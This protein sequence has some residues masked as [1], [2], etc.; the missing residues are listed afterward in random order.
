MMHK[1]KPSPFENP[2]NGGENSNVPFDDTEVK[3]SE[4]DKVQDNNSDSSKKGM[5]IADKIKSE[6]E[7]DL[8]IEALIR[9]YLPNDYEKIKAAAEEDDTDEKDEPNTSKSGENSD[10]VFFEQKK[11]QK[12]DDEDIKIFNPA[13]GKTSESVPE[14]EGMFEFISEEQP[15]KTKSESYMSSDLHTN[16]EDDFFGQPYDK[17]AESDEN[18]TLDES[19]T[20]Q[21][22]DDADTVYEQ[23]EPAKKKKFSLFG[24]GKRKKNG[25][26]NTPE[27]AV[28]NQD[29]FNSISQ[30][31]N[32]SSNFID[33]TA[34]AGD[35]YLTPPNAQLYEVAS[36]DEEYQTSRA[37]RAEYENNAAE[38][39]SDSDT[40]VATAVR[41]NV[42]E[43]EYD[44]SAAMDSSAKMA[45]NRNYDS[46][47]VGGTE[48]DDD[49]EYN[50]DNSG[51]THVSY[52]FSENG[53][54]SINNSA[55][56]SA[57]TET[58]E[59]SAISENDSG[60]QKEDM[61]ETDMNLMW[62]LGLEDELEKKVGK[63]KISK[64]AEKIKSRENDSENEYVAGEY[65]DRS[66]TRSIID[67][68]KRELFYTKIKL[69]AS[70]IFALILLFFE[71]MSLIKS[72]GASLHLS[73]PLDPSVY[74][75]V[76]IMA[77]LQI[78]LLCCSFAYRQ[79]LSGFANIF[80]GAPSPE[81]ITSVM[82]IFS[83]VHSAASAILTV[84][85]VEPNVY[86][87][88]VAVCIVMT[89]V[90]TLFTLKREVLSF[91][92]VSSKR[93]KYVLKR[94]SA[95]DSELEV[96]AFSNMTEDMPDVLKIEKTAFVDGFFTRMNRP[97]SVNRLI[98]I[99][100]PVI[101]AISVLFF[102][103][104]YRSTSNLSGAFSTAYISV[105]FCFP[106][107]VFFTYS[108]PF[109]SA[110]RNAYE[111]DSTIIGETSIDEYSGASVISF[112][113]RNVFPSYG[114]K[115][116]NINIYRN[117]RIDRVLYYAS[118]IFKAVGGPL[119]DVFEVATMEMEH[120]DNVTAVSSEHGY[121]EA[122]V[123]GKNIILGKLS[124]I[125]AGGFD[126]PGEVW[127][128]DKYAEPDVSVMYMLRDGKMIAKMYIKYIIDSDFEFI[129]K[130]L[131]SNG[132]CVGIKT[133]DPNI[134]EQ[135]IGRKIKINK[136][137]VRVLR[138]RD[139]N[140]LSRPTERQDSGIVSRGTT[141]ALLQTVGM[142][143]KVIHVRRT[144]MMIKILSLIISIAIMVI[145]AISGTVG[146]VF[147]LFIAAYQLIWLI[148]MIITSKIFI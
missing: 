123:D 7:D 86:N 47:Y 140:E 71:N 112:D 30:D 37:I 23:D 72:G 75:V 73:G 56:T 33:E 103:F 74:P 24:F 65:T 137:P 28:P 125:Q 122:L 64:F 13:A 114:V 44:N 45:Q 111:N 49:T 116:Q 63:D 78:L 141:K 133:F 91:N 88:P 101:I 98:A 29:I 94:L 62:A 12:Y 10:D 113:D 130:Q 83:I 3:N 34:P 124:S 92:I 59:N 6:M 118:S 20:E 115:V 126:I 53:T 41:E 85:P 40:V 135:M 18:Y 138:Y 51:G 127:D 99:F 14:N 102:F 97:S 90:H 4:P 32:N 142:C 121:L 61:D 79:I 110:V 25:G 68:Y 36:K 131:A 15:E 134:D 82:L 144:N 11:S 31:S 80:K 143:D 57:D 106:I 107:S 117:Y 84:P 70:I 128:E 77:D 69:G 50:S 21:Y 16:S 22:Y 8:D 105:L 119:S 55:Q 48:I 46:D 108:V 139:V 43:N 89:L 27:Y 146:T 147:S 54:Y 35:G 104:A 109:Y 26:R 39:V 66:Q 1:N 52:T 60:S 95:S 5:S 9:K 58:A 96:N 148:P 132:L 38:K 93:P 145:I 136:Y 81:S 76:Y 100:I 19:E 120:S 87:F 2:Q 17:E 42:S 129:V 67:A